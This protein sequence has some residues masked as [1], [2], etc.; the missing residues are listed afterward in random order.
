METS[1]CIANGLWNIVID[2]LTILVGF[3]IKRGFYCIIITDCN[4][5]EDGKTFVLIW[6]RALTIKDMDL[7]PLK[8]SII[9]GD[10]ASSS[11]T[12]SKTVRL[13]ST[14]IN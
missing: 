4:Q 10:L 13:A 3:L 5:Q 7:V 11:P 9:T 6:K 14:W 12:P 2:A 1:F 8:A